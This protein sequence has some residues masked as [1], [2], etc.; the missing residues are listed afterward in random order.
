[1][2]P[3]WTH[4]HDSNVLFLT[5]EEMQKDLAPVVRAIA[6]FIGLSDVTEDVVQRVVELSSFAAM[7][8]DSKANK[9]WMPNSRREDGTPHLRKGI[10]GSSDYHCCV[11]QR[12]TVIICC[13]Y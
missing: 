7:K 2:L 13:G 10:V 6:S 11:A 8:S 12:L 9:A 1:M 3:W 4:R 5:Y